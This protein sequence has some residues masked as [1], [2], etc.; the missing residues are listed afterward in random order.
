M[1]TCFLTAGLVAAATLMCSAANA[2]EQDQKDDEQYSI[3]K[4]NYF[5]RPAPKIDG[6]PDLDPMDPKTCYQKDGP[7]IVS[8]D[9]DWFANQANEAGRMDDVRFQQIAVWRMAQE[10]WLTGPEGNG[11]VWCLNA[12]EKR[13]IERF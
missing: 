2:Q 4:G 8:I 10:A 3:E 5:Q 12:I 1:R 13:K 6:L 9:F 7:T 11:I